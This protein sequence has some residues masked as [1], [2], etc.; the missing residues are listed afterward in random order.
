MPD[1]TARTLRL[2]DLL[3]SRTVWSGADLAAELE[4]TERSVRRDIDRLR[5]LGYPVL[6]SAGHGGGYQLGP[7]RK[8]PPLLLDAHEGVAVAVSLQLAAQ[9][10]IDGLGEDAVRALT[11]LDQVLPPR[12]RSEVAA[13]SE[14]IDVSPTRAY[15]VDADVLRSLA[16]AVRDGL[17]VE[18][19]YTTHEGRGGI[20]RV[21]PYRVLAVER[22]W[23][24][25]AF[26]LDRDDWRTFRLDRITEVTPSTLRFTPRE[27]PDSLEAA[28][29]AR[30]YSPGPEVRIRFA[31]EPERLREWV[32]PG[33]GTIEPDGDGACVLV[34]RG[35]L[36]WIAAL[37]A[38]A[39][40]DATPL[41]PPKLADAMRDLAS[42]LTAAADRGDDAEP[43][44]S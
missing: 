44:R 27:A 10:G 2:L 8:L 43:G 17:R 21:E 26:D 15:P 13:L 6:S 34:T 25:H 11:K 4:V 36:G 33:N 32:P 22:R 18:F 14:S 31:A 5:E 37:T 41:A 23:Y 28:R 42:R 1:V 7:G 20:R 16:R 19:G 40:F 29:R 12:L 24:L 30:G 39:P 9:A 3:Q 35:D 38:L